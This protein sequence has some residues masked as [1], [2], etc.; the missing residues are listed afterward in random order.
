M[1]NLFFCL[2][3]MLSL[4][5]AGKEINF[6]FSDFSAG[7]TPTNFVSVL[8]GAG[9]PGDWKIAL[10]DVPP[11][12]APLT[13]QASSAETKRA[14]LTQANLDATDE[15][16]PMFIYN[17]ETFLDFN[18]S[19]RFKITG[20]VTEQMAGIVFRYQNASNFYVFRASALGKNIAFYKM[21]NGQIESPVK[22]PMEIST[23]V[24]HELEVDC[25]GVYIECLLDGQKVLP[26]ITDKTPFEGKAGFWT[27]SDAASYFCDAKIT[28]TPRIAAAQALVD[29]IMEKQPRI[30]GLRIYTLNP[31]GKPQLIA[32]KDLIENGQ[33]GDDTDTK[34]INEGAIFYGKHQGVDMITMPLRDHNGD[35]MAAVRLWLKSFIGE[36]Q[37]NA[38]TRARMILKNMEAEVTSADQLQR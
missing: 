33:L 35:P 19:T 23:N 7:A 32:S 17:G 13:P 3:L 34:A 6:D 27:K 29:D 31:Q 30:L 25:S 8:A 18:F 36:T 28:Y 4:S 26:T 12:L 22:L 2:S 10:E 11:L 15:R 5:A 38:V 21:I 14:V 37:N 16:Y 20:G 24:W 9:Q 1:R